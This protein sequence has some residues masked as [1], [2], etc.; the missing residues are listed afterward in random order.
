MTKREQRLT[1]I[2]NVACVVAVC[3]M[4]M[5]FGIGLTGF[6]QAWLIWPAMAVMVIA[7]VTVAVTR[8]LLMLRD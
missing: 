1:R 3:G 2:R 7:M 5:L 6:R 8:V 4:A